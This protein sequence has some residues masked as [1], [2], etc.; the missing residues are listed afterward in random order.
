MGE[1]DLLGNE[2][3]VAAAVADVKVERDTANVVMA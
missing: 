3:A 2:P 1:K